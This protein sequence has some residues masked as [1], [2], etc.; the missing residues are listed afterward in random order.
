MR[1]RPRPTH[2]VLWV[3][4]LAGMAAAFG[5][6]FLTQAPNRLLSGVGVPLSEVLV[7][8]RHWALAPVL[9]LLAAALHA[10]SAST[11][12]WL[13]LVGAT[14]LLAG[15]TWLAGTHASALQSEDLPLGRTSLGGGYWVL[16]V[17]CGLAM[18][19]AVRG[20]ST[21]AWLSLLGSVVFVAP[22]VALVW[23]GQLDALS[24]MKE[25]DNRRD[26][27]DAALQRHLLLVGATLLPTLLIG[28]PLGVLASRRP[29]MQPALLSALNLLQTVPSIALFALLMVPLAA[30]ASRWPVLAHWGI[31]GIGVAPAVTALTLYSLLPT[32]RSTMA[33][34]D[35]IAPGVLEAARG[36]GMTRR[37]LFWQVEVPLAW[38]VWLAGLRVTTVQALGLAMVSALIGAGGFGAVMFQGLLSSAVDLVLL[39]VVPVVALAVVADALFKVLAQWTTRGAR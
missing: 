11:T 1:G 19:E 31:S 20:W 4:L 27:F 24:L 7:G 38:P 18:A 2:P 37:Q 9:L 22:V 14:G 23:N 8:T 32:V 30:L 10:P 12:R 26:V 34:L 36:M 17:L 39:G 25:Y 21:R 33:G 16:A 35:Q 13:A 28:V 6:P 29:K 3:L 5:L 15:L